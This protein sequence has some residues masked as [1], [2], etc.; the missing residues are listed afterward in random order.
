MTPNTP[1]TTR[2]AHLSAHREAV[3]AGSEMSIA[4]WMQE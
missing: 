1:V 4:S 2:E 3:V